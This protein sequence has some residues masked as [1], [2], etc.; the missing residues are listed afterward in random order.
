MSQAVTLP[1]ELATPPKKPSHRIPSLDGLRAI[2]I[3]VVMVGHVAFARNFRTWVTDTYAHY[4]VLVFFVISGYLITAL[5]IKEESIHGRISLSRFYLRR[6]FRIFPV[7]YLYLLAMIPLVGMAWWKWMMVGCYGS[8]YL[9]DLPWN[10]SHLWSLSVEEQFYLLWPLAMVVSR[11][12]AKKFAWLA[13]L[14]AILAQYVVGKRFGAQVNPSFFFPCVMDSLAAG[15]LLA[16]YRP[17]LPRIHWTWWLLVLVAPLL[18]RAG[19][20]RTGRPLPQLCGH[21]S[22]VVFDGIVAVLIIEVTNHPP[23]WLNN[24]ILVWIGSL[25]YSLYVWQMP[26]LNPAYKL[27]PVLAVAFAFMFASGSYYLWERPILKASQKWVGPRATHY[28]RVEGPRSKMW[29]GPAS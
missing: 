12:H 29:A 16:L 13:L 3:L 15:C 7:A 20:I 25:S 14:T 28:S 19:A 21:L 22:T 17:R 9:R 11:R 27:N 8:T 6:T 4:G 2:S 10:V 1:Y 26:F 23:Q 18:S 24:K 5:L